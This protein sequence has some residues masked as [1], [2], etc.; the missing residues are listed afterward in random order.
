MRKRPVNSRKRSAETDK[1]K[2]LTTNVRSQRLKTLYKACDEDGLPVGLI[3]WTIC[4]G[5]CAAN[6]NGGS[7]VQNGSTVKPGARQ[8]SKVMKRS[9]CSPSS[10]DVKSW[11]GVSKTLREERQRVLRNCQG[12]GVCRKLADNPKYLISSLHT[13]LRDY[14]HG[15]GSK[16]SETRC[17]FYAHGDVLSYC[18]RKYT[19]RLCFVLTRRCSTIL[20]VRIQSS[21]RCTNESGKFH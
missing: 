6:V 18:R 20:Q 11:L 14:F 3:G 7:C 13:S 8:G 21:R 9:S 2:G 4:P 17:R 12:N 15:C 1:K 16:S 10:L 19:R 5:A